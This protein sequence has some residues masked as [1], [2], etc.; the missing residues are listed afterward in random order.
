MS[1]NRKI[2]TLM[3]LALF[4]SSSLMA[5]SPTS[6]TM[7]SEYLAHSIDNSSFLA[8]T[9]RNVSIPFV[10]NH[11]GSSDGIIDPTE[12]AYSYTDPVS[13]V[14]S[15]FE[16]NGTLLYVGLEA[17]TSGWIGMAWQNTSSDFTSAGL[18]NSDVVVGYVPGQTLTDMWRVQGTDAVTVHYQLF[19]RN[20]S[21]IQESDYPDISST[22]RVDGLSALQGYKDAIIG[23]RIGETR[24]F[25]IPADEAYNQIGHDLYGEALIYEIVLTRIYREGTERVANPADTSD[26]VFSD[27]HGTNTFQHLPDADQSRILEA[28]GSDNGTVTQIEYTIF[29][30]STDAQ[31]IALIEDSADKYPFVFMFG[32]TEELNGLPVQHSY[33][34]EPAMIEIVPNAPPTLIVV[35]PEADATI[36]W[37]IDLKLNATNDWIQR[38][39][40]RIDDEPWAA[41]DYDFL[42]G[43]WRDSL[44]LSLYDEGAHVFTFNA[45][46]L[47]NAT[48]TTQV[49]FDIARPFL[50]LL[51]MRIEVTRN[52]ITTASYGSRVE[53][54]YTVRNNGSAPISAID[55]YLPEEYEI[56]FLSMEAVDQYENTIHIVRCDNENGFMHWKLHFPEPVEFQET[57]TFDT[58]MFMHTLFWLSEPT[59]LEYQISFLKYPVMPYV[60]SKASFILSFEGEGSLVPD[61]ELPDST[62]LNLAPFD[63]TVFQSGLRLYTQNIL[64]HR[65]TKVVVDAWGWLSYEETITLENTGGSAV[66]ATRFVVPAFA[67]NVQVYDEVGILALSQAQIPDTFNTTRDVPIYLA[68]DRFGSV[69]FAQTYKYTFKVSYVVQAS[70]YQTDAQ[71]GTQ[72][73]IPMGHMYD[74]LVLTHTVDVVFSISVTPVDASEEHRT[75]YGI[76]DTTYQY[77]SHNQTYRLPAS[78]IV[79]YQPSL[80]AAARPLLFSLIMGIIAAFYV[81]YRKVELPEEIVGTRVD[82]DSAISQ[83]S[84]AGAPSELLTD[85]ANLYSR[86]TA[87][88][89]DLEKLE[90]SRRRGKV[91]KREYMIRERDLKEQIEDID[92]KLPKVKEEMTR[93]GPHYRDLVAQLELQDERIQGAKAGLRQLLLRKKK[94]RISRVAFE[95][96]R[97]DYLKTI[98]KATSATDR[99]LLS[100]QEEAGEL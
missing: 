24:Y 72:L 78:F 49:T 4:L 84:Q 95:K 28:S 93:Y 76:F 25:V 73:E 41:L 60:L 21:M 54:S 47:S 85:F 17:R 30:N 26:L 51:G 63:E 99:I 58:T 33:W 37:V 52:L 91:K 48:S 50:A 77:V 18:N 23:M 39:S 20:G 46:D 35:S 67:K 22:D 70:E 5:F 88:N 89:M 29:L 56:H 38:A 6:D 96:S 1:L 40:Y 9:M 16:Q 69:G 75:L 2:G 61:E 55:V 10:D 42:T 62:V 59:E 7:E 65:T 98:Q 94:Q 90:A 57:Y 44:D 14:K 74:D 83:P 27:E 100:I 92:S 71:G 66:S 15:Y 97:Q 82:D 32:N 80:G 64:V 81:S 31:D 86:K 8:E 53:D 79:V 11:Y 68:S 43:Y 34:T 45:T 87:L 13:G 12:Y 19:L 36:E 3:L